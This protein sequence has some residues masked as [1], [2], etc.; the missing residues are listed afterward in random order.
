[1]GLSKEPENRQLFRNLWIISLLIIFN[2]VQL[3][4][5]IKSEGPAKSSFGSLK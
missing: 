3:D 4:S 1:M 5:E 2:Q